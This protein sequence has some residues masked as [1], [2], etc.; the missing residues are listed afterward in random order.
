MKRF[1]KSE[2]LENF[3][4]SS[5]KVSMLVTDLVRTERCLYNVGMSLM[6]PSISGKSFKLFSFKLYILLKMLKYRMTCIP[7]FNK[8]GRAIILAN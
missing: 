3:L 1:L 8:G 6:I 4:K 7:L 2:F 5:V